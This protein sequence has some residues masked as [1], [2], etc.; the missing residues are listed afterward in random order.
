M[1]KASIFFV[2]LLLLFSCG[3]KTSDPVRDAIK[4]EIMDNMFQEFT[5]V[6]ITNVEKIDS[7]TFRTEL[8][9]RKKAF[10]IKRDADGEFL[11]K[12]MQEGKK[13]NASIKSESYQ[14][15]LRILQGL[16]SLGAALAATLD[17]VAYYDYRFSAT[18]KG[19]D[20]T[21][22]FRDAYISITPDGRVISMTAE[23]RDLHKS[24]GRVI[25]G[26]YEL[27]KGLD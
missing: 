7:T 24:A 25:P 1:K 22:Q 13:K 15:D 20:V 4:G 6:N 11:L 14:N 19:K 5:D 18:A 8:D 26:Y 2:S 27:V 17:D 21:M 10:T 23:R 12:Y 3:G 16:D 9:R